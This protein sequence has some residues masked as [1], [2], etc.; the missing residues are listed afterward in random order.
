MFD[1]RLV[2]NDVNG[3][4]DGTCDDGDDH[5]R[6]SGDNFIIILIP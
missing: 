1:R 6:F 3:T 4:C 5:D 2:T